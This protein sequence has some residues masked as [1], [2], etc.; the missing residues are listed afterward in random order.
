[1]VDEGV[2]RSAPGPKS[3]EKR[4]GKRRT[5]GVLATW[6]GREVTEDAREEGNVDWI[7][8]GEAEREVEGEWLITEE[9]REEE[10]VPSADAGSVV[11]RGVIMRADPTVL[12][13]RE[14]RPEMGPTSSKWAFWFGPETEVGGILRLTPP[15]LS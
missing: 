10:R 3:E 8:L 6:S 11:V 7:E 14:C 9:V 12:L 1:M 13:E 4:V 5:P 2:Q 15:L